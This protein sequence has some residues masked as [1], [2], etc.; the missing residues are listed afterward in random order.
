MGRNK[1][2]FWFLCYFSAMDRER[3]SRYF[4]CGGSHIL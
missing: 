4:F 1:A 2:F 3:I